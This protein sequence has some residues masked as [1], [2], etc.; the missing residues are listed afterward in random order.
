MQKQQMAAW[1]KTWKAAGEAL[2]DIKRQE[3]Q[4]YDY[5]KNLP[6]LEDMLQWAYE[7]RTLRLTSGL[8]EQQRWFSKMREQL[9]KQQSKEEENHERTV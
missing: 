4:Q 2:K 6:I 9:L 1:V 7:H 8:V 3:L 5:A